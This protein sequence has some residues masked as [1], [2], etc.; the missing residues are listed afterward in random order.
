MS[1]NAVVQLQQGEF[2]LDVELT[3]GEG[4]VLAV[5]GPNGSGKTT[6]LRAICGLQPIHSG[7]ISLH[8]RVVDN[9]RTNTFVFPEHR[10]SGVVFQDNSLF[11]N[12]SA[13]ENVAF[14]L[15][16]QGVSRSEARKRATE[17]IA[18][19]GLADFA[20]RRPSQLS[21]GQAQ[22]IALARAL[23]IEPQLL[24]LD[25]PMSAFDAGGRVEMRRDLR[26]HLAARPITTVL[27]THDPLD[28]FA[29]AD[30]VLVL[31]HGTVTQVGSFEELTLHPRSGHIADMI[32]NAF[33]QDGIFGLALP[34][35]DDPD[36]PPEGQIGA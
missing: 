22:R 29:L 14:G 27:V 28:A 6:L 4:E 17:W 7:F 2:I 26:A 23:A 33:G 34:D 1:I 25:E 12:L 21:G 18:R 24:L 16:A 9:P 5:V 31:E 20:D 3:V 35:H 32:G 15:R 19:V 13:R 30:R 36:T 11:P 8:D 10:H